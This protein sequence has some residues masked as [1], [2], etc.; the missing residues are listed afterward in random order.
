MAALIPQ[1][2]IGAQETHC[3]IKRPLSKKFDGGLSFGNLF[4]L[5]CGWSEDFHDECEFSSFLDSSL[6]LIFL[7]L[8]L[9]ALTPLWCEYFFWFTRFSLV[10]FLLFV[11]LLSPL[12]LLRR[13]VCQF[14]DLLVCWVVVVLFSHFSQHIALPEYSFWCCLCGLSCITLSLCLFEYFWKAKK[15]KERER[16]IAT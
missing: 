8:F 12:R 14:L 11:Q 5:Y 6:S 15:G 16:E 4:C 2:I 13:K 9:H 3:S 10:Y 7:P 1:K